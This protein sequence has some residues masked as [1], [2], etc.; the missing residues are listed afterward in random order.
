MTGDFYS[1]DVKLFV[2][3]RYCEQE[4]EINLIEYFWMYAVEE[5]KAEGALP[6]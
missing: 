4:R 6:R 5:M 1:L 3:D 2:Y